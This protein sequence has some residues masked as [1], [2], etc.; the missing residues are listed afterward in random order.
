[1][2]QIPLGAFAIS[3]RHE[4][5]GVGGPC[6]G[7]DFAEPILGPDG[8]LVWIDEEALDI[9]SGRHKLLLLEKGEVAPCLICFRDIWPVEFPKSR[10]VFFCKP[11]NSDPGFVQG[12]VLSVSGSHLLTRT[13]GAGESI[14]CPGGRA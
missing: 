10:V 13:E 6:I 12:R 11:E 8:E 7:I 9:D 5:T 3:K 1:M 14:S 4:M 2:G